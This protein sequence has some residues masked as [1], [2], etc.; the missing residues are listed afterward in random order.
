MTHRSSWQSDSSTEN[1][2]EYRSRSVR[3]VRF[4]DYSGDDHSDIFYDLFQLQYNKKGEFSLM[5]CGLPYK[6]HK[7]GIRCDLF[8]QYTFGL[9]T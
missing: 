9:P 1:L 8:A 7:M 2:E 5:I 3:A 6:T 4:D